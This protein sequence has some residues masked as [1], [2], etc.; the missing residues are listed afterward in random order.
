M[1]SWGKCET[2]LA[3]M[4]TQGKSRSEKDG[5]LGSAM[6][7][8]HGFPIRDAIKTLDE[9]LKCVDACPCV[10]YAVAAGRFGNEVEPGSQFGF[11]H[12]DRRAEAPRAG[13]GQFFS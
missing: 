1:A 10:L 13:P 11:A 6:V 7:Y 9:T 4:D 3:E 2:I 8:G 5:V 12:C